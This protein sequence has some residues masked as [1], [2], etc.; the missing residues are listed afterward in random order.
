[1]DEDSIKELWL[2]ASKER[3]VEINAEMLIDSLA[4]KIKQMERRVRRRDRREIVI[5]LLMIPLFGWWC[6][7]IPQLFAKMG[8]AII[9]AACLFVIFKL[10]R[11]RRVSGKEDAA[12]DIRYNLSLSLQLLRR[13]IKLLDTVLWWYL[14]PFFT[15]VIFFYFSLV[16][17]TLGRVAYAFVVVAAYGYI[18]Y[19]NK[20][21]VK[22]H[23][24]PLE[25]NLTKVLD[26]LSLSETLARDEDSD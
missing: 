3:K 2:S 20:R 14:L 11:A 7:T 4:K 24:K 9:V 6:V 23:L 19:L 26:D 17:N 18:Y 8:S 1:M 13:Q 21:A 15:G 10:I 16:S 5:G 22:K 25:R 12:S